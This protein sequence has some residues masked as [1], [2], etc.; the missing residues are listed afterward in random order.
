MMLE[1]FCLPG[2]ELGLTLHWFPFESGLTY[3]DL[4]FINVRVL[5]TETRRFYKCINKH[6]QFLFMF[7]TTLFSVEQL[8]GLSNEEEFVI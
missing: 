4:R 5:R 6:S 7:Y 1:L 8:F 3:K 2:Q